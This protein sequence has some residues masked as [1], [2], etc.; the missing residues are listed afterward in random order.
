M[1]DSAG[2]DP[3]SAAIRNQGQRLHQHEEVLES[4]SVSMRHLQTQQGGMQS[5][6]E[7]MVS[8][9]ANQMQVMQESMTTLPVPVLEANP[10]IPPPH[11]GPHTPE[12][13]GI[14]IEKY[15][16]NPATCRSFLVN[17]SLLFEL[18]ASSYSSE[19][20]KVATVI[21]HLTGKAREWA[22]A[23]WARQSEVCQSFSEF[24]MAL[25]QVFEHCTPGREAARG[26]LQIRQG[27]SRVSEYA[28][29]FRTMAADSDWNNSS[30]CD[31]FLSGLSEEIKDL[32]AP[33][34]IPTDL[35]ALISLA[36]KIDNRLVER[37]RERSQRATHLPTYSRQQRAGERSPELSV[38]GSS[39]SPVAPEEPMQLGRTRLSPEERQ[40]RMSEG[41]CIYCGQH[42]HF[43]A[44]CP[45]KDRA[46][47]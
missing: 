23:E 10:G 14:Q 42:G 44:R 47:Q 11:V 12:P 5:S 28:I 17:C 22:T 18:N 37:K 20:A 36:V 3:I 38:S 15:E 46:Q 40:K 7:S 25:R 39:S 43:L 21:T 31:A 4:L 13:R 41:R 29:E 34:D 2:S 19:R 6:L 8:A 1:T 33:L 24:S 35:N 16:G 30:L 27:R 9:L 32:L 45:V 26:L